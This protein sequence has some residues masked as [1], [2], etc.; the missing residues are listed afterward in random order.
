MEKLRMGFQ[1]LVER[2]GRPLKWECL[3]S[4]DMRAVL[5]KSQEGYR[6][7]ALEGNG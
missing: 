6:R 5:E 2:L 1:D 7:G 4:Q 3:Q